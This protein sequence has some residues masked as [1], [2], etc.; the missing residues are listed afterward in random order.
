MNY[1]SI[2][3]AWGEEF[4]KDK[5]KKKKDKRLYNS[6]IPE[7]IEESSY[8]DGIHNEHCD[9]SE[10]RQYRQHV[11]KPRKGRRIKSSKQGNIEISYGD[12][13]KEYKNYKK[14]TK[15]VRN[16]RKKNIREDILAPSMFSPYSDDEQLQNYNDD[17]DLEIIENNKQNEADYSKI[18]FDYNNGMDEDEYLNTQNF[19]MDT[20]EGFENNS[21][22]LDT[23]NIR[24]GNENVKEV[25]P[26]KKVSNLMDKLLHKSNTSSDKRN[27][28]EEA[29]SDEEKANTTDSDITTSDGE[30]IEPKQTNLSKE[31]LSK[32]N[33]SKPNNQKVTKKDIDY[34]LNSLNR[35]MNMIIKQMNKS[36]FFDDES[37]DNIHDLILFILF[38]IFIIFIL[39]SIYKL[40]KNSSPS[41]GY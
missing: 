25:K 17:S 6:H 1:C 36:Q 13:Q 20:I 41:L 4:N 16:S 26:P 38:G 28:L 8:E 37:Q 2:E 35:S 40:G 9:T 29:S 18:Q 5:K 7:Y 32:E 11:K 12:A 22:E 27:S 14:E 34:R 33:L 15:N 24:K 39:D 3:E 31:N 10:S 21:E 30:D 23:L 19:N